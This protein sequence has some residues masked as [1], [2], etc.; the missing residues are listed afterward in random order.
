MAEAKKF[1]TLVLDDDRATLAL[2]AQAIRFEMPDAVVLGVPSLAAARI[3]LE[4]YEF[5]LFILDIHLP[6]G[7]GID[8][9]YEIQIRKPDAA[10]IMVTG[11]PLPEHRDQAM[12]FGVLNFI[13]K[14]IN[15]R[16]LGALVRT[17]REKIQGV[18]P[19]GD[20][21][22]FSASL[23]KLTTLD[24]IQLKCLGHATVV[25]DFIARDHRAG[26]VYFKDGEIIHAE[27][28]PLQGVD[29]F[30]EIVSWRGGQVVEVKDAPESERTI[31]GD[32]QN[33]L[34]HAVQWADEQRQGGV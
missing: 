25:L 23:T 29:A 32:W 15:P 20:T 14:P 8:F 24:I 10:V 4:R 21:A 1:H 28:G 27:V 9:L 17:Q 6:D 7:S 3:L 2:V 22:F 16:S 33:L 34:M 31:H 26:R 19:T 18:S 30:N 5:D 12:A 11:E 13:E